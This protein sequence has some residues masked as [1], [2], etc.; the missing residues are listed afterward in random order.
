MTAFVVREASDRDAAGIAAVHIASWRAAYPGI[1]PR[2]VL[3][4][5][6]VERRT[7]F[8]AGLLGEPGSS[9]TWVAVRDGSIVGF[10]GVA[11]PGEADVLDMPDGT[12][13]LTTL[14]VDPAAWRKGVGHRL[15]ETA[16]DSLASAGV[17]DLMLW[18]FAENVPARRFYDSTGWRADGAE[19]DLPI[20]GEPIPIVRY[21]RP[22]SAG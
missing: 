15:L 18:V 8:W 20:G 1:V 9:R 19:R 14:Y 13:D 6:S 22:L 11:P 12:L 16:I 21:R 3:D 10:L 5:L 2:A 17:R 4:G 7:D